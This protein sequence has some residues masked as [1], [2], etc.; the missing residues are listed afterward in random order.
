MASGLWPK[1][2]GETVSRWRLV[3][4]VGVV[5]VL[6]L[7]LIV[8]SV[9]GSS[10]SDSSTTTLAAGPSTST[11]TSSTTTTTTT[12]ATTLTTTAEQRL[13]EVEDLLGDLWFG[14]FDAIYRKDRDAL[15]QVV[16]TTTFY[17]AGVSAM[18][19]TTFESPP[20]QGDVLLPALEILLDRQDCLAVWHEVDLS[21]FLGDGATSEVVSVLWADSRYGFRFA[22]DW[23]FRS[24]LWLSDCDELVREPTP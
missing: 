19:S 12:E 23:Q 10:P 6:A 22:T 3:A 11:P 20:L 13:A 14:W 21:A 4:G 1:P 5:A 8:L 24:D 15:W 2:R 17:D 7:T 16:A 18:E 9:Q